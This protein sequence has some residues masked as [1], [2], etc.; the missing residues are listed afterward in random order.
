MNLRPQPKE[1]TVSTTTTLKWLDVTDPNIPVDL[2]TDVTDVAYD[3]F[4]QSVN[5]K[6]A[7]VSDTHHEKEY[8]CKAEYDNGESPLEKKIKILVYG[9]VLFFIY[10]KVLSFVYGKVL[11]FAV[12]RYFD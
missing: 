10:G 2:A 1:D 3:L 9:K 5:W 7:T 4:S 6:I 11:V 12:D 8:A